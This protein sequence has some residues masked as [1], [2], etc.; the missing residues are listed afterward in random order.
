MIRCGEN[1]IVLWPKCKSVSISSY[2]VL[3]YFCRRKLNHFPSVTCGGD[4][5][6]SKRREGEPKT[7][8]C[9]RVKQP[10]QKVH[11]Q[12]F[13]VDIGLEVDV[14]REAYV[15]KRLIE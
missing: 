12:H 1:I 8:A 11:Y 5:T 15:S 14:S 2:A 9:K 10:R 7:F 6:R 3:L 4:A 13:E